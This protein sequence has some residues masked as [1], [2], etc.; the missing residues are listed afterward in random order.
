MLH[1]YVLYLQIVHDCNELL[2]RFGCDLAAF[3]DDIAKFR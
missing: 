3:F 2:G 1:V